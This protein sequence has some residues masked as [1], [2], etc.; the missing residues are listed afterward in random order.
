MS[1]K[2]KINDYIHKRK[3]KKMSINDK[4]EYLTYLKE[5]NIDLNRIPDDYVSEEKVRVKNVIQNIYK[6]Y[7]ESKLSVKQIIKCENIGLRFEIL[8][9][10]DDKIKF[11]Q[12]AMREGIDLAEITENHEKYKDN[13]IYRYICDL[14]KA[15]D[16]GNLNTEQYQIC[17]HELKIIISDE[18]K[19][20]NIMSKMEESALKN[21]LVTDEISETINK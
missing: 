21:I 9:D 13:L 19:K 18:E 15:N 17:I 6:M 7:N 20:K 10:F 11:L 2:E 14:R 4:I 12:K 3:E 1:I 8:A 5:Q 16:K